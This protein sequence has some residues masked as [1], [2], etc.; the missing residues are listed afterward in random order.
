MLS[1]PRPMPLSLCR[2]RQIHPVQ[3]T[4]LHSDTMLYELEPS[5]AC[6]VNR[7][8]NGHREAA[9]YY[10]W[11]DRKRSIKRGRKMNGFKA[12]LAQLGTI[13]VSRVILFAHDLQPGPK[14]VFIGCGY[15]SPNSD[16]L[17]GPLVLNNKVHV[18][19]DGLGFSS[20]AHLLAAPPGW[21][22]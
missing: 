16:I 13:S 1:Y 11:T 22:A 17:P 4:N 20:V 5:P 2:Q 21:S 18:E 7:A 12:F 15:Y 9:A 8:N 6:A 3:E 14:H 10:T 19:S